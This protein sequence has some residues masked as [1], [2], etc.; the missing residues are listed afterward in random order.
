MSKG[1]DTASPDQIR[2]LEYRYVDPLTTTV[3][4]FSLSPAMVKGQGVSSCVAFEKLD[5]SGAL[6]VRLPWHCRPKRPRSI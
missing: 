4:V 3:F 2:V 1:K 5:A 6:V